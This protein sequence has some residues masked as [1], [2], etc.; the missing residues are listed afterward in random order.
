M[1]TLSDEPYPWHWPWMCKVTFWKWLYVGNYLWHYVS[2]W[3]FLYHLFVMLVG[4]RH[5]LGDVRIVGI[6]V[7]SILVRIV[8]VFIRISTRSIIFWPRNIR[9]I[10]CNATS[11]P[12][13]CLYLLCR[14]P[15][16]SPVFAHNSCVCKY[17]ARL[18]QVSLITKLATATDLERT[19]VYYWRWFSRK[20]TWVSFQK[21][22]ATNR[23]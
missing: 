6:S 3:Y 9:V 15:K 20:Y 10:T 14:L 8:C 7:E 17:S 16:I 1:V 12:F 5:S 4:V 11:V 22:I 19:C 23:G 13:A 2:A 18:P 21:Y